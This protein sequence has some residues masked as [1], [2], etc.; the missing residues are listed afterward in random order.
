MSRA[1]TIISIGTE[2]LPAE[3]KFCIMIDSKAATTAIT[4]PI[5][6]IRDVF[7]VLI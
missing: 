7:N 2:P 3:N 5:M 6:M 4:S 1:V